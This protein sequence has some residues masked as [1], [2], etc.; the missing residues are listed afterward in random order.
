MD[1]PYQ[2]IG[3]GGEER[4]S[5]FELPHQAA[6]EV[7]DMSRADSLPIIRLGRVASTAN[8]LWTLADHWA[9]RKERISQRN[10]EKS[11]ENVRARWLVYEEATDYKDPVETALLTLR[12][13]E[14]ISTNMTCLDVGTADGKSLS[15]LHSIFGGWKGDLFGLELNAQ[16]FIH[17]K[18]WLP[19]YKQD[20]GQKG[21]WY[22]NVAD[23][24]EGKRQ[25]KR[26]R[27]IE[28]SI[29]EIPLMDN[30]VNLVTALYMLYDIK[31]PTQRKQAISELHRVM[32]PD[33]VCI[34]STSGEGNK[35]EH[36]L[37]EQAVAKRLSKEIG[38]EIKPPPVMNKSFTTEVA[39]SELLAEFKHVEQ[40]EY[41]GD[42][43]VDTIAKYMIYRGSLLSMYNQLNPL[44][45]EEAFKFAVD[46][47]LQ[48]AWDRIG[49]DNPFVEKLSRS[50]F[51]CSDRDLRLGRI[52]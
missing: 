8:R 37:L 2:D 31:Q 4:N 12:A 40:Y 44:P 38:V 10:Y 29:T 27:F 50:A 48:D 36:R 11:A 16:Q 23:A 14:V 28:G 15:D 51:V 1:K 46:A 6:G 18:Y 5:A 3:E 17:S 13:S 20:V 24:A 39:K 52:A 25:P 19:L 33:G 9:N 32:T 7:S 34:V 30:S 22:M 43:V 45:T 42:F 35:P 41:E 21:D 47:T 49:S 26:A